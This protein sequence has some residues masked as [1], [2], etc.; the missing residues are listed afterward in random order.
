MIPD[1][2]WM[3][4][5]LCKKHPDEPQRGGTKIWFPDTVDDE[6]IEAKK[7]CARCPVKPDCAKY[8]MN[9][10]IEAK[11]KRY[12]IWAE[13]TEAERKRLKRH[14]T[15]KLPGPGEPTLR[16]LSATRQPRSA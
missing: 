15:A 12:G 2:T 6:G 14:G 7:I 10:K 3:K 5:A 8:I 9:P 4:D 13:M 1:S 16:N 11:K